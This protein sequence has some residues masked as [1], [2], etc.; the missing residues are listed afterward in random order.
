MPWQSPYTSMDNN[1]IL[2]NDPLGDWVKGAG[3]FKNLFN[4]DAKINAKAQ[5]K[6][7][8]GTAFKDGK[9]WTV[10][11]TT[12]ETVDFGNGAQNVK[13]L[14]V[15]HYGKEGGNKFAEGYNI[16]DNNI[17]HF[18]KSGKFVNAAEQSLKG[19]QGLRN[20]SKAINNI[21]IVLQ[22][23][24]IA[25]IGVLLNFSSD[26]IDTGLDYKNNNPNATHNT[27]LKVS[28]TIAGGLIG[29]G[30]DKLP[31][32]DF[33]KQAIDGAVNQGG[34]IIEDHYSKDSNE[35]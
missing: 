34:E 28:T 8:G 5:A 9:G 19:E 32:K 35:K 23:T 11:Y 6:A 2:F 17:D 21:G 20:Y 22:Y 31:I 29:R 10:N 4:S 30:V 13:T 24:P 27:I 1:P 25:P 26:A 14:N 7:T 12:K 15:E 18:M 3:L 33:N 16:A